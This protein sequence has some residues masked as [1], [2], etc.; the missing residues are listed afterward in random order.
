MQ[1]YPNEEAPECSSRVPFYLSDFR[2]GVL[3]NSM[4]IKGAVEVKQGLDLIQTNSYQDV[5]WVAF[6]FFF[7][8]GRQENMKINRM[9][10]D[11]SYPVWGW[12]MCVT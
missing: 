12:Y 2:Q 9:G 6:I 7:G 5:G 11:S 8:L 1:I 10:W 4:K 3:W